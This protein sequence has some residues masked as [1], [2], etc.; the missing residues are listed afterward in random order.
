MFC[1]KCGT[2]NPDINK[3]CKNCGQP[4]KKPQPAA[5]P[6]QPAPAPVMQV[7]T[8][9]P[10][11]TQP[12]VPP[13]FVL[14]PVSSSTEKLLTA[15]GISGFLLSLISLVRYPYL[16]G[17]IAIVLGAIV[18]TK[19][20]YRLRKGVIIAFLG[21]IIGLASIMVDLLYTIL[22]PVHEVSLIF[23]WLIP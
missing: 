13:G 22:F 5:E 17:V 3:F 16:C 18:V 10:Q 12:A 19:S 4:L 7:N 21:I 15:L 6:I 8:S 9:Q 23:F 11:V 20:K 14:V 2:E 1:G